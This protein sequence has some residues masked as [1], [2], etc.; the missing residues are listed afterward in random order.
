MKSATILVVDDDEDVRVGTSMRLKMAGYQTIMAC[1]GEEGV[2]TAVKS[3]PDAV[4]LDVRMPRKDGL[5]ALLELKARP[6]TCHIPVVMLS[7]SLPDERAALDS[8]A[9]FFIRKPYRGPNLLTA[10]NYAIARNPRT[11]REPVKPKT[12]LIIEDDRAYAVVLAMRCQLLGL[13]PRIAGNATRA[14]AMMTDERP[15]LILLDV[16]IPFETGKAKQRHGLVMCQKL[17]TTVLKNIPIIVLSGCKDAATISS[18]T[19]AG[20][21]FVHKTP[22]AWDSLKRKISTLLEIQNHEDSSAVPPFVAG[23]A[24]H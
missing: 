4:I 2:E 19:N 6:E 3:T 5:S 1:D 13:S 23:P 12:V 24:G 21:H 17:Q 16:E 10:M 9:Q 15:D 14:A 7:A 22:H 18:C 11:L 8:G 20:A